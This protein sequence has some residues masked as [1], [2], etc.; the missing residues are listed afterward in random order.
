MGGPVQRCLVLHPVGFAQPLRLPAA[1]VSS[2]LTLSPI[3]CTPANR[4]HRLVCSLLHVPSPP[5]RGSRDCRDTVPC[6]VR[7]FL[8]PGLHKRRSRARDYLIDTR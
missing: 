4:G 2:Y 8:M 3:T 5:K 1:L 6:G 7:T